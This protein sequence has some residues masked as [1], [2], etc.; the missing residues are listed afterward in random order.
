MPT[1]QGVFDLPADS[2][3]T[4]GKSKV[5]R[6]KSGFPNTPYYLD[7]SLKNAQARSLYGAIKAGEAHENTDF[8]N[9]ST[10]YAE[11]NPPMISN[12][13]AAFPLGPKTSTAGIDGF[14]ATPFAPNVASPIVPQGQTFSSHTQ[15]TVVDAGGGGLDKTSTPYGSG[16]G[17]DLGPARG[18]LEIDQANPL[19]TAFVGA[20]GAVITAIDFKQ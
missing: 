18:S 7:G 15:V 13:P 6:L 9:V 8:A 19:S 20:D 1:N 5:E 12:P 17:T 3:G 11:N 10:L 4:E 16:E 2:D 14:P